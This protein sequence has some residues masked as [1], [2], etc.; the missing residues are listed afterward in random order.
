MA[1]RGPFGEAQ[2]EPALVK[3]PLMLSL[4]KHTREICPEGL[5][6]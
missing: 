3:C 1:A 2:A 6:P 5:T 4:S